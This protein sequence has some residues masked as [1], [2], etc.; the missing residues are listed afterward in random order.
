L[1]SYVDPAS[2][3]DPFTTI[4]GIIKWYATIGASSIVVHWIAYACW[5]KYSSDL[6]AKV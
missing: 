1:F 2:T 5:V 3:G 6:I 4:E